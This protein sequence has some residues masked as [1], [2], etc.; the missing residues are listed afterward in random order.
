[1]TWLLLTIFIFYFDF[2]SKIII[3]KKLDLYQVKPI[4]PHLNFFYNCNYG[5]IFGVLSNPNK[6][7]NLFFSIFVIFIIFFL[8]IDMIKISLKN[9]IKHLSYVLIIGGALGNLFDRIYYGFVIDFIDLYIQTW[10]FATFNIADLSIFFGLFF[11]I[12]EYYNNKNN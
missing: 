8:L 10:H 6:W 12:I 4:L 1:M 7:Q 2:I 11:L 5:G 9:K 3:L